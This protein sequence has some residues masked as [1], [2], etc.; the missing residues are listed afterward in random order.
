MTEGDAAAAG[1]Q[2]KQTDME[3]L[4]EQVMNDLLDQ[5]QNQ[6]LK[7]G[8]NWLIVQKGENLWVQNF[9]NQTNETA[10]AN[11]TQPSGGAAAQNESAAEGNQTQPVGPETNQTQPVVN[12]TIL[13]QTIVQAESSSKFLVSDRGERRS[14]SASSSSDV[15]VPAA[16]AGG[17]GQD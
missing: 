17:Q 8:N 5:I 15:V 14:E 12:E 13:N 4:K 3:K 9:L 7:I 1:G 10:A 6:G 11:E 16:G 2:Q